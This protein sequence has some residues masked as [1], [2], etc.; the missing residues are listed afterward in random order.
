MLSLEEPGIPMGRGWLAASLEGGRL[1]LVQT[2]TRRRRKGTR[3][4]GCS[5]HGAGVELGD[6]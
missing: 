6:C 2:E 3:Y 5:R 1:D 4:S